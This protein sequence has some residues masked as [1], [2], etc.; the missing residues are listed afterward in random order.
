MLLLVTLVPFVCAL[1]LF[2][3]FFDRFAG[4]QDTPELADAMRQINHAKVVP[5]PEP[6]PERTKSLAAGA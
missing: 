5:F 1:V 2:A 3:Y 4:R 6:Q